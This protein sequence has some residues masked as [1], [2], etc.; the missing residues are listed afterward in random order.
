[1][2]KVTINGTEI[3]F[4]GTG[5]IC[6]QDGNIT[7]DGKSCNIESKPEINIIGNVGS[8]VCDCSVHV[9]GDIIGKVE[10][11]GS[12]HC[13]NIGAGVNAGGSV[14]ANVVGGNINAGG[15]IKING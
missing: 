15:S 1:M 13:R 10:A 5:N 12:V 3:K 6:V 14:R 8:I 11:G 4:N 2:N 7:I 9:S